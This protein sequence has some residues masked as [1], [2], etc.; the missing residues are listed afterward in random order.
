MLTLWLMPQLQDKI[1]NVIL[2][3]DGAPLHWLSIVQGYFDEHLPRR[4]IGRVADYNIPLTQWS[5]RS[6]DLTHCNL[7]QWVY[8]KERY[9]SVGPMELK[10][11]VTITIDEL[12]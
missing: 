4:W 12:D 10:Q 6:S 7:Y 3:L 1:D 5:P 11:R 2:Q 8:V 9:S